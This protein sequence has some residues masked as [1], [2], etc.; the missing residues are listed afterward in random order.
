MLVSGEFRERNDWHRVIIGLPS[1][2][3]RV[4]SQVVKGDRV[5]VLGSIQYKEYVDENN[6]R[7]TS[8]FIAASKCRCR[9]CSRV[10]NRNL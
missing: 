9:C 6:K 1:L 2:K 10:P 7:S 8:S 3:A 5:L 4:M